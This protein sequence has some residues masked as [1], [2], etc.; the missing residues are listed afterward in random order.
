[1]IRQI[2]GQYRI[3]KSHLAALRAEVGALERQFSFVSFRNLP[4]DNPFIRRCDRLC[5]ETLDTV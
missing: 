4:R 3:T 2:T 5:N 1:V